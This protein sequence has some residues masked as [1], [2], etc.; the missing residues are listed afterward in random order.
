MLPLQRWLSRDE[1]SAYLRA[2]DDE[3]R[4]GG[5]RIGMGVDSEVLSYGRS[6]GGAGLFTGGRYASLALEN[7]RGSTFVDGDLIVDGWLENIGG[8][9]FVRGNVIAQTLFTSGY[10]VILGE[11][12][13]RRL[14]GE[15]E[16]YGTCVLGDAYADSAAF[17]HNHHFDVWGTAALA[18]EVDD[19]S[20]GRA[21]MRALLVA[22]G[23]LSDPDGVDYLDEVQRGMR[24][25][26]ER[27][28]AVPVDWAARRYTPKAP[29]VTPREPPR[30]PR[31]EILVELEEWLGA[32]GLTQREQLAA[33]RASWLPRLRDAAVRDEARRLIRK[34]INSKKLV[35]ARDALLR[36]LE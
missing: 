6:S 25:Y 9:V 30:P 31:P 22:W 13:V 26:G 14:F 36:D 20:D 23:A 1:A 11:L 16:Q 2:Y 17:S 3:F 21:A 7:D 32:T 15:D 34:A 29:A 5:A 12:R 28:G 4:T 10:L 27:L 19:E 8:L 18:E 35:E 24:A 33:L